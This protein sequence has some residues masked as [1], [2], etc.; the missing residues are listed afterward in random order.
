MLAAYLS[1]PHDIDSG[2]REVGHSGGEETA[3][4]RGGKVA[5]ALTADGNLVNPWIIRLPSEIPTDGTI[6]LTDALV[7]PTD[8]SQFPAESAGAPSSM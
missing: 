5:L 1:A 2:D 6:S 8:T 7:P 4:S 3:S